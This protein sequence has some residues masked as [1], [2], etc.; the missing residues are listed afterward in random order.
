MCCNTDASSRFSKGCLI[1]TTSSER[2]F[3]PE[4]AIKDTLLWRMTGRGTRPPNPP[5]DQVAAIVQFTAVKVPVAPKMLV[6]Q[7]SSV[8]VGLELIYIAFS[9]RASTTRRRTTYQLT[10][11]W[12]I[13]ILGKLQ[14]NPTSLEGSSGPA[15]TFKAALLALATLSQHWT[16][17]L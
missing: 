17:W 7:H 14:L 11:A 6:L 10:A 13:T 12:A 5:Q 4:L 8:A 3:C 9:T 16:S 2:K 15:S 1:Q